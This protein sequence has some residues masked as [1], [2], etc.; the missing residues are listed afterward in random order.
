MF[1][2]SLFAAVFAGA[3]FF[4]EHGLAHEMWLQPQNFQIAA[5][6][7]IDVDIIVGEDFAGTS[8]GFSPNNFRRLEV[9]KDGDRKDVGSE[10]GAKPAVSEVPFGPGLHVV[11]YQSANLVTSY[12]T[13]E[14]FGR[15]LESKGL[16]EF[17]AKHEALNLEPGR[18]R[19]VY[20][21]YAKSLIAVDGGEGQ[22]NS[23]NLTVEFTAL[24]NPYT[25]DLKDGL[26]FS[27]TKFGEP[28]SDQ[29]VLVL[30]KPTGADAASRSLKIKTDGDGQLTIDVK[31]GHTYLLDV[32]HIRR[33]SE[34]LAASLNAVWETLWASIT[35]EVPE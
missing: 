15:F 27:L 30:E 7:M 35:F 5:D 10:V 18:F 1:T 12:S 22:D 23:Q 24:A 8:Y 20:S 31:P 6:E 4:C 29:Q 25:D 19:E 2:K 13:V 28:W 9:S 21:R 3:L 32:V 17:T 34:E 33:P 26:N 14:R 16:G 11:T